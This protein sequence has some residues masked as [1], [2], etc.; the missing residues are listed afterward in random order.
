MR[1]ASYALACLLTVATPALAQQQ[2][3]PEAVADVERILS[4][5]K[6]KAAMTA[7]GADHDRIIA[8]NIALSEVPAPPFKEAAKAKAFFELFS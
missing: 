5:A 7:L 4:H 2:V 1:L 8:E 6:Y 3:S